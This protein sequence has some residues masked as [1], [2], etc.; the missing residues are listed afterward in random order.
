MKSTGVRCAI[1]LRVSTDRQTVENQ[2]PDVDRIVA[3][4]HLYVARAYEEA[5]SVVKARPVFDAMVRDARAG[6]FA[7]LVIWSVD[8]FGRSALENLLAVRELDRV[9]VQVVSAVEAV[10]GHVRAVPRAHA[11]P[12]LVAGR[13]G[14]QPADRAHEGRARDSAAARANASAGPVPSVATRTRRGPGSTSTLPMP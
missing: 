14:A 12:D 5:E 3:A 8:R 7:V 10:A 13:A 1:Y 2:R 9:G 4:R 11:L 6:R